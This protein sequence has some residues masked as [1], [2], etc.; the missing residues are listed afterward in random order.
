MSRRISPSTQA[1]HLLSCALAGPPSTGSHRIDPFEI[2]DRTIRFLRTNNT[3]VDCPTANHHEDCVTAIVGRL[4]I[5]IAKGTWPLVANINL[6]FLIELRSPD[7]PTPPAAAVVLAIASASTLAQIA[8][9]ASLGTG[10]F[11]TF[12]FPDSK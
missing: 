11:A 6:R 7:F 4:G 3:K 2:V 9:G 12:F 1:P 5:E 8:S 10:P